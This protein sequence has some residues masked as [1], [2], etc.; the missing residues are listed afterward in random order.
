MKNK[1]K[2]EKVGDS[3]FAVTYQSV[4]STELEE[5]PEVK[6]YID[7][8]FPDQKVTFEERSMEEPSDKGKYWHIKPNT[9]KGNG[10]RS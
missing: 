2:I 8:Q 9:P 1:C 3:H 7:S 5:L 10:R 6:A 4:T